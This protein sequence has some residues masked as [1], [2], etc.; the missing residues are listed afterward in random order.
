MTAHL[1]R[2]ELE[3]RLGEWP[4]VGLGSLPTPLQR[5][6]ALSN[7]IGAEVW[8][9]RDDLTGFGLG[10][11]KVRK[12][13]FL[14][15]DARRSGADT[16]LTVGGAQSNHARTVAAAAAT[17]GMGCH[18]VLGGSRPAVPTGNV[19]LDGLLGARMHFAGTEDWD[20]LE[21]RMNELATELREEGL[22]PYEMPVGGS[23]SLGALGFAAAYLEL[24]DQCAGVGLAPAS[25]VHATSS[26][27]TQAGLTAAARLLGRDEP[28]IVGVSVAKTAA[29]L[30]T[31]VGA[32]SGGVMELLGGEADPAEGLVLE[33]F[34]GSGY[35]APTAGAQEA[36]VT[37]A[38]AEG[39]VCDPVYSAKALHAVMERAGDLGSPIVFWHTGG[40]PALFSDEQ[41]L[42]D[43]EALGQSAGARRELL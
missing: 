24:F 27:G 12:V 7:L 43:W 13:E 8:I 42:M 32:I 33:G 10:G 2:D 41:Q 3:L 19:L 29:D 14:L 15:A 40:L 20:L 23:T 38:R 16:L 21:K 4:R 34:M 22:T 36:L 25:V 37:L 31:E 26:G 9:K 17:H 18:V 5:M 6:S 28:R 11:N 35:A 1:D 30:A 39:I